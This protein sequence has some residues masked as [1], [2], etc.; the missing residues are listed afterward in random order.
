[1]SPLTFGGATTLPGAAL[2]DLLL[3]ARVVSKPPSGVE[4]LSAEWESAAL[5]LSHE[6][7]SMRMEGLEPS[8]GFRPP[9]SEAGASPLRH[10]RVVAGAMTRPPVV[11]DQ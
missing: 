10:T 11:V 1:M 5:P 9:A 3:R 8:V 4:P 7:V 2:A 6:G